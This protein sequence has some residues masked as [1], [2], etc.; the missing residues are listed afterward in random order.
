MLGGGAQYLKHEVFSCERRRR[1]AMLGGSWGML[2]RKVLKIWCNLVHSIAHFSL[3]YFAIFFRLVVRQS[4]E[5]PRDL[6]QLGAS[7]VID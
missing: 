1:E 7:L 3:H 2:H 6:N 4:G 5:P